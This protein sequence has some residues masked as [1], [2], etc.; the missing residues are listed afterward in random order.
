MNRTIIFALSALSLL[1]AGC[2]KELQSGTQNI[3]PAKDCTLSVDLGSS[4]TKVASQSL[5]NERSIRNAQI[6]VFDATTGVID[7]VTSVGFASSSAYGNSTSPLADVEGSYN[8]LNLKCSS[9]AKRIVA[10]VNGD[11]DY[12]QT[13]SKSSDLDALTHELK[14]NASNSF[15]MIGNITT[16]LAV[17]T[18]AVSIPVKR[19]VASIILNSVENAFTSPAFQ[20]DGLFRIDDIYLLNVPAQMNYTLSYSASADISEGYWY[21]KGGLESGAGADAKLALTRETPASPIVIN[22]GPGAKH[23]TKH[24]LYSYP[25]D[26]TTVS[27]LTPWTKRA[28]MLVVAASYNEGGSW[29]PCYYPIAITGGLESN[30]QYTVN[31]RVLRIGSDNPNTPVEVLTAEPTITVSDWGVGDEYNSEI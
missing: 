18:T 28:T 13:V 9:G 20:A 21:N 12:T 14:S 17:G 27:S 3:N 15:F 25:N 7:A 2:N 19:V 1:I 31:L 6:F 5:T 10:V 8:A 29:H 30:K 26:I 16:T 4:A 24:T 23:T 22:N 11:T